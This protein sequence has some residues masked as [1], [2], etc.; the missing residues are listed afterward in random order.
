MVDKEQIVRVDEILEEVAAAGCADKVA[1][2]IAEILQ[3]DSTPNQRARVAAMLQELEQ[4]ESPE[5]VL[6]IY[7]KEIL[8]VFDLAA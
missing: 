4:M 1:G 7:R 8:E 3:V 2:E 5:N 6:G